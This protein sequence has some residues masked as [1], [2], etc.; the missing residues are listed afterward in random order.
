M[1]KSIQFNNDSYRS[2]SWSWDFGDGSPISTLEHPLHTYTAPGKYTVTLTI[3]GGASSISKTDFI[4]VL[5][6][7]GTPYTPAMGG[8]FEVNLNDFGPNNVAGTDF[9]RGNS[10]VAG[11]NGFQSASNAWVTGLVGNYADN[12]EC[13]LWVPSYNMTAVGTYTLGF[14]SRFNTES[15]FDGFRV[16]YSLNKGDNWVPLGTTTAANW[17]NN[18]NGSGTTIFPANEAFFGGN[19]GAAFVTYSRDISFLAGNPDV[20]FRFVFKSDGGLTGVGV[21]IDDFFINGPMNGSSGLPVAASELKGHW[22]GEAAVLTWET[23][24]ETNNEGFEIERSVDGVN[25]VVIGNVNGASNTQTTEAYSYR[26]HAAPSGQVFYRYRQIDFTGT[27]RFSNIAELNSAISEADIKVFPNPFVDEIEIVGLEEFDGRIEVHFWSV[28]G[29]HLLEMRPNF[30]GGNARVMIPE[31]F[32]TGIC[33][34][35]IKNKGKHWVK[36]LIRK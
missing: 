10:A 11:K 4:H 36:T 29:K 3:N 30:V 8:N 13:Q 2:T 33:L 35:E 26:D 19:Q 25:F 16:E 15:D 9:E 31:T 12:D 32:P 20:A 1:T 28:D 27:S 5:P 14:D 22:E 23:Y 17:Y 18:N 7:R 24:Q 21:A 34:I 6:D